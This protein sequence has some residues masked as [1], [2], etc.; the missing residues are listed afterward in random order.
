[1][2]A[3][4]ATRVR[5]PKRILADS[6]YRGTARWAEDAL[7]WTV[8]IVTRPRGRFEVRPLR[9]IVERTFG[10]LNRSRRLAKCFERT[11]A[12]ELAFLQVALIHLMVKRLAA[13]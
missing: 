2:L 3:D 4:F 9:W 6:S 12:S 1:M 7:G 10:W 13:L 11:I 5:R 8:E